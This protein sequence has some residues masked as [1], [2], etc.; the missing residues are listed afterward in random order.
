MAAVSVLGAG[1]WGTALAILLNSNG[2]N[3]TIW[4]IIED[5][6]KELNETRE[7]KSKLPGIHIPQDIT[8]TNSLEEAID[9]KEL[10]VMAVP[11]KFVRNTAKMM[12]QFVREDQIIVNVAKGLEDTTL[13]TLA[14]VIGEEMPNNHIA[15]LSGPSHAEEVS[16]NIPTT[17][18]AGSKDHE[19]AKKVQDIFMNSNFRVY[20][21]SDVTG[22]EMGGA[23]KNV[24]ALAA[25]ISD[26]IGYGDNTK[27]AL[28]TRGITE[29]SRLGIA[30]GADEQTFSGLS[31]IGDL[32]V[33]CTSMH[34]RNRRAGI[35]IGKGYKLQEALDEVKMVVEG[36]YTAKAALD[37]S[38]KYK[39]EM[40][41]I[42]QV[43]EV[44]F[45]GK[46]TKKA[47]QDLM[48]RDK[49]IE[50]TN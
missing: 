17:C 12:K 41:I 15:V 43:N 48:I 33:T 14:H 44:L 19:T 50:Y 39:V 21:S 13:Y 11:S 5:E 25:G 28:M 16:R 38:I 45:G 2:H 37:L 18:V 4:S 42:R 8:I 3:V 29:I 47:V 30:M 22:I 35:L 7:N 27:A 40:P 20:T 36:V 6:V 1:S 24:I 31:G 23:L 9:D 10:L 49:K 26:G 34:S 32:I 46:E